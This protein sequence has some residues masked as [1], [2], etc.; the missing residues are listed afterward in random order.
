MG[1]DNQ[2][3]K[4]SLIRFLIIF[5]PFVFADAFGG[6]GGGGGGQTLQH[7]KSAMH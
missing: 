3:L 6:G 7:V 5:K 1:L 4:K 2:D